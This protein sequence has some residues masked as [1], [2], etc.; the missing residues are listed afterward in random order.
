[1]VML[2][3]EW[4]SVLMKKYFLLEYNLYQFSWLYPPTCGNKS[5]ISSLFNTYLGFYSELKQSIK[6]TGCFNL[7]VYFYVLPPSAV[8]SFSVEL[9]NVV[10]NVL[11]NLSLEL[12]IT[13]SVY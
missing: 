3:D 1:M 12:L 7:A 10:N 5:K 11:F 6:Y 13:P 4:L 9:K 8:V 2:F